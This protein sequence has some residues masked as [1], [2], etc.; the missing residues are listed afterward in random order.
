[1]DIG[2]A[3]LDTLTQCLSSD[4]NT[5]RVGEE[6]LQQLAAHPSYAQA[7]LQ[8]SLSHELPV[9]QRQISF[10]ALT[11]KSYVDTHWSSKC[12]RFTGPEPPEEVKSWIMANILRGLSEPLNSIRVAIAYAV[13]KIAHIDWPEA[14][15][16]FFD[17]LMSHLKSGEPS[18]V[19][20][21]MRV[22]AEFVRDDITDQQFPAV[23]PILLPELYSIFS[24]P[25]RFNSHIRA[26]SVAILRDFIEMI[27][28][29][30]EEH[31]EV[32]PNY[33]DPLLTMWIDGFKTALAED[34]SVEN[35]PIKNDVLRAVV[36]ITRGFPK[37]ASHHL[38]PLMELVWMDLCRFSDRYECDFVAPAIDGF[39]GHDNA[40]ID[41][42]GENLGLEP[43]LLSLFE[44]TQMAIKKKA[45][46]NMFLNAT[47][48]SSAT[49]EQQPT[50]IQFI[51]VCLKYMRITTEME[52]NWIK[53]MNQYIQ[54]DGD[55]SLIFNVRTAVE[56]ILTTLLDTY[57]VDTLNALCHCTTE[58][59]QL[60]GQLR[61][62]G[63]LLWWKNTEAALL[64][65]GRAQ[66]EL[67][68][69]M[70]TGQIQYDI[71]GLFDH[72]V[73]SSL[74]SFD[75]PLL[76]GRA[77]WFA[78]QFA[79]VL[80]QHLTKE[81]IQ[82]AVSAIQHDSVDFAM[83]VCALKAIKCFCETDAKIEL[84]SHQADILVGIAALAPNATSD[85]LLLLLETLVYVI[86]IDQT[87]TDEHES[88]IS[89]LLLNV[90]NRGLTDF[91][92]VDT[93][94]DI[95]AV[96]ATSKNTTFQERML[97]YF[98]KCINT[99]TLQQSPETVTSIL[100]FV[101]TMIKKAP[102][103]FSPAYVRELLPRVFSVTAVSH[104]S[105]LLQNSEGVIKALV[106][107]DFSSITAWSNGNMTGLECIIRFIAQLLDPSQSESAAMFVGDLVTKLIQKGHAILAP[108]LPELLH[109]VVCRLES[110]RRPTFIQ[111]LVLVFAHLIQNQMDVVI[112][113]LS[114]SVV[115]NK[116]GLSILL[117]AWCDNFQDFHGV[118]ANKTSCTALAKMLS[119]P[120]PLLDKIQVRGDLIVPSETKIITR[121]ISKLTPDKYAYV[122]F[123]CRALQLLLK[124]HLHQIH[125]K[126][127]SAK[128]TLQPS[129][130]HALDE[131]IDSD[132][133]EEDDWED[134]DDELNVPFDFNQLNSFI[135]DDEDDQDRDVAED[136]DIQADPVYHID[137]KSF[138]ETFMRDAAAHNAAALS[139][140]A[141]SLDKSSKEQLQ[142]IL[143][144]T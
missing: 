124:E 6:T 94:Q 130:H 16:N 31:P 135:Y 36:K 27:F 127:R 109:S 54:D 105:A 114:E 132:G 32:V 33:L 141:E 122:S 116:D 39:A 80:P 19:H 139:T 97:P 23:A 68:D 88:L 26:K 42:D 53:D 55:D 111:T 2:K 78:S 12:E 5:L 71:G 81:Y 131:T 22:L 101:E 73:L 56:E 106:H 46:S 123:R 10:S 108:V 38:R 76:Q 117:N 47:A 102:E 110:A 1:M 65:L 45:F 25:D 128:T 79:H 63:V 28:M 142:A 82:G 35:I 37:Q 9:G 15:P 118:F 75:H 60:S 69:A 34:Y 50:L 67:V 8:C 62:Q 83:R 89:T 107:R 29:V 40:E 112:S 103:P 18:Q 133:I 43:I 13:S 17:D 51:H 66:P 99:E 143:S 129:N 41:S 20:G 49:R 74:K 91:V 11:L 84:R 134:E 137:V 59:F 48:P 104:D 93:I 30:K 86:K 7:L 113:F 138:I 125:S 98:A 92:V 57:H 96:M 140:L 24:S 58:M 85:S 115:N 95:I 4:S 126:A 72:I 14:W 52:L 44:F 64:A 121:S 3:V 120:S 87:V 21:A 70:Q 144:Q 61:D 90:L 100:L 119:N 136:A 77:L